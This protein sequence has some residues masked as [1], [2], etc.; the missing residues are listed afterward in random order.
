MKTNVTF[1]MFCDAFS[2]SYKSNFSYDGKKALF[3]Y[4]EEYDEDIGESTELDIIALCCEYTEYSDVSDYLS[5]YNT[6]VG[7]EDFVEAE[8]LELDED[9]YEN[10][11]REEIQNK[12]T[13]IEIEG[14]SGFIIQS[15]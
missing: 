8:S 1:N 3:D 2:E 4:L 10:A 14:T 12:T 7:K 15:Y 5:N 11:I 6:D 13:L 9:E